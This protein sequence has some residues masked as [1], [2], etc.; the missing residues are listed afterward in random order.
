MIDADTLIA[1]GVDITGG[2]DKEL[3]GYCPVHH[4]TK[5]R[6]A[7][8]PKWYMNRETGAWLCFSC[9]QRG[10]LNHLVELLGGDAELL[11]SI[12]IDVSRTKLARTDDDAVV[13]K[14]E[15]KVYIS[16]YKFA[17]NPLPP[18]WVLQQR[19]VTREACELYNVRWDKDG[20][21]F[22]IPLY[23]VDG[24]RLVGWQEKSRGYFN[25]VPPEVPKSECL[26]G[27]QQFTGR[28]M[29][30]VESPLDVVRL[31]TYG[32]YGAVATMGSY[33]SNV[34][35][36]AGL[37][38]AEKFVLAFDDDEA[39]DTARDTMARKLDAQQVTY[40]LFR[41][42]RGNRIGNAKA[43]FKDIGELPVEDVRTGLAKASAFDLPKGFRR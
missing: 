13:A 3:Q 9:G 17:K 12:V 22:L 42:P 14:P 35:I 37:R 19:D 33:V 28:E 5:G 27:F 26:F 41:Y 40:R 43:K 38:A 2:S 8:S 25:N 21:C 4:L 11:D 6:E 15:P 18:S 10:S 1:L 7:S 20:K 39:G 32:I 23:T 29:I 31:A 16:D 24:S 30:Y 36:D 34:Q